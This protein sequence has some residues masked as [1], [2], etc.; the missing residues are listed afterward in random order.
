MRELLETALDWQRQGHKVALATVVST[1]GSSPRPVGSQLMINDRGDFVG[2]VSGGC[3]ET[4]VVSEALDLMGEGG[5]LNLEYGVSDE[6]A[7]EVNL[8]CGG[9]VR[10]MVEIA[11]D[12]DVLERLKDG[13][14]IARLVDLQTGQAA[15][16]DDSGW[17]GDLNPDDHIRAEAGH[18][19]KQGAGGLIAVGDRELFLNVYTRARRLVIVGA[20]HIAQKL[21]PMAASI[22]YKVT[23]LDPRP[24]F[25]TEARLPDVEIVTDRMAKAVETLELDSGTAVAA[26]AHDPLLDD[27]VLVAALKSKV[28]YIGCL[29]SRKTQATRRERLLAKGFSEDDLK[30]LYGPIGYDIG[31]RSPGEIAVSI[32]AE[33]IAVGNGK[34]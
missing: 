27:P 5:V 4:F 32:L 33:I 34:R 22:G 29:G 12:T 7:R 25:A 18:L 20:V 15:L 31:G 14:P 11:P 21:V 24:K 16:L 3:I 26:L 10:V 17:G 19:W 13:Q 30:R 9:N 8:A 6:Q 1:W 2:S 23:V 28:F